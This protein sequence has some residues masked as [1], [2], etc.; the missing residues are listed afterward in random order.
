MLPGRLDLRE[1][2]TFSL[3]LPAAGVSGYV[4]SAEID[5]SPE[6]I[7]A[8]I[9][10]QPAG[11][12]PPGA[13]IPEV[14]VVHALAPGDSAVQVTQARPWERAAQAAQSYRIAVSVR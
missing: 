10:Q 8:E 7:R 14:L 5:G 12:L 11:K 9:R 13:A 1:G 6:V 2:E 3:D 4:W